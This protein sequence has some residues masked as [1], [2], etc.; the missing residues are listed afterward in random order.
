MVLCHFFSKNNA[1][2]CQFSSDFM[3]NLW[4]FKENC[5][6]I[7]ESCN[8]IH[9]I[10]VH[11]GISLEWYTNII[12]DQN[13]AEYSIWYVDSDKIKTGRAIKEDAK[14]GKNCCQK[15]AYLIL[16][17]FVYPKPTGQMTLKEK[18]C[19]RVYTSFLH[20]ISMTWV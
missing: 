7:H 14:L 9:I 18:K 12:I 6:E 4:F 15:W 11:V 5:N 20:E 2:L 13:N 16:I 1:I 10:P 8:T 3:L 17:F 19:Y